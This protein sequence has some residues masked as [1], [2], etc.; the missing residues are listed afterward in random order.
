[1]KFYKLSQT[2]F[3]TVFIGF[4]VLVLFPNVVNAEWIDLGGKPITVSLI[5][6]HNDRIVFE[7]SIGGFEAMPVMINNNSYY[8]IF[9]GEESVQAEKGFPA[10][11]DI[12]RS[13]IIPDEL[14]MKVTLLSSEYQDFPDMPIAPSKGHIERT[15]NPDEVPYEFNPFYEGSGIFPQEPARGLDPYILRDFRGMVVDANVF[16]YFPATRTL[17]VY[18]RMRIEVAAVGP[19][20]I[21]VLTNKRS[22]ERQDRQFAN[23]YKNH[24]LNFDQQ[25]YTPVLEDGDL[26]IITYDSF[27]SNMLPLVEWKL[28][29]GISTKLVNFSTIGTTAS[30]IKTYI[31][32]EYDTTD[33]AYVLLVGDIG[34]IPSFTHQTG[35]SDP[36]YSLLAG[37][38]NYPEI[39]VGRFSAQTTDQVDT[40]V[41]R[42]ITYEKDASASSTWYE[43]GTGIASD[44]GPGHHGE[45]D[46]E[47]MDL[48]RTDLLGYG[49]VSVD[50]IYDPTATAAQVYNALNA[51]RGIVNYC[52]HGWT[53]GW[54][55]SG[56]S[57][58]HIQSNLTNVDMLPFIF[59]VACVNGD[60]SVSECFAE[61]WLRTTEGGSPVGAVAVY[62]SSINQ[63]WDPPMTAQDEAVDLLIANNMYTIGGL[64]YNGSCKMMDDYGAGGE[65][66]F[67][68]WHIFGDPS[69]CVRTAQPLSM[70]VTHDG[71]IPAG[72]TTY[73]VNVAGVTDALCALYADG[74]LYGSAL[75]DGSGDAVIDIG[76]SLTGVSTLTLTVTAFD[77]VTY[78][79]SVTVLGGMVV[80]FKGKNL[81]NGASKN[82][83]TI[84]L[85]KL[86]GTVFTFTIENQTTETLNLT[87]SPDLVTLSGPDSGYFMVYEQPPVSTLGVG[88][89]TTFKIRTRKTTPPSVPVGWTKT[90]SFTINIPNDSPSNPYT[91]TLSGTAKKM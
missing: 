23:L 6:S 76:I 50:Q 13:F 29:K 49:Y 37:S 81:P 79:D 72:Q 89:S 33:L 26:L 15:I 87:G 16:Q 88:G 45:Y 62:M 28:Q 25:R 74:V 54:S 4:M 68:T 57:T 65:N 69:L 42:T 31:Q 52:G 47:H 86:V 35:E 7:I 12:L 3:R 63:S 32:N 46:D 44:Q 24:F 90:F 41:E 19:G 58:S 78:T 82:V 21:N 14:Q 73:D 59:S 30:D 55:S 83:G 20:I 70:T 1:M 27:N 22:R 43:Y 34:Q 85:N 71:T 91:F 40:Q 53:G 9:I 61:A 10:L 64:F 60:F 56:F 39:F 17:R 5:E 8:K 38:D 84:S 2:F 11:P 80:T 77:K 67:L 18:T 66:M 51:G 48:I 36:K 75:T